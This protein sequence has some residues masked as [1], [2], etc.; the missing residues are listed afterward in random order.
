MGAFVAS[1]L[2]FWPGVAM[3]DTVAQ[4]GQV[5]SG[6][7]DD[8]HPPALAR[9]WHLLAPIGPGAVPMLVL[10]L[11]GYW[12]GLGLLAGALVARGRG[13]AG[14][15]VL[16]IGLWPAFLGWQGVVLKDAQMAGA[17]LAATGMI[18]WWRLR[19][20]PLPFAAVAAA[21][22]LIGY[23]TLVRANAVFATAPLVAMLLPFGG[24]WRLAVALFGIGATLA[25]APVVNHRLLGAATSGVERTEAIYDL[26][27]IATRV[28][29][30]DPHA[31]LTAAEAREVAV[32]GCSRPYFWDPLGDPSRCNATVERLRQVPVGALYLTLADAALHH[33]LAYAAH[34]L[35]H[36]NSTERWLVPVRWPGA[37]PPKRSEPND[38]GLRSP[39]AVARAW[40]ELAGWLV[41]R[42]A[43]WPV[44]WL[45]LAATGL[46]VA[47]RGSL[48]AALFVSA[49]SGEAS[50]AVLS[51]ASDWR[52]HLWATVATALG[53]VL[54]VADRPPLGRAVR[55][56][57]TVLALVVAAGL[58]AR[59]TLPLPPQTYAG[60]LG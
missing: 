37:A 25:V 29:P 35:A 3:Y 6:D 30:G 57:G 22:L 49:L 26:A 17:L 27:G 41:E 46:A 47:R 23:A 28:A 50:F 32:R 45:V 18:G 34:R 56:G 12:S 54:L 52:Y 59:A 33:P 13:R 1:V 43:G 8:W 51:I 10:Q 38:L 48:A 4:Y 20:R 24:R 11:A 7:Y 36:L 55:I 39:G 53:L 60:M 31:G 42:P 9:L 21:G 44:A 58:V 5:L 16:G 15:A 40:Q 14:V 19:G 2:L